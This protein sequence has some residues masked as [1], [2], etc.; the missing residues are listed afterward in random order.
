MARRKEGQAASMS[1]AYCIDLGIELL[2]PGGRKQ[3]DVCCV[4][5]DAFFG[6]H[7]RDLLR[8]WRDKPP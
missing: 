6:V 3:I 7:W 2:V 4:I 1:T 8:H 5:C